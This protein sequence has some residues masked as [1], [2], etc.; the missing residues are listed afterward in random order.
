MPTKPTNTVSAGKLRHKITVQQ[1]TQTS[2]GD[3]GQPVYG[4][5]TLA[6]P[7]ASLDSLG[8]IG[9][10]AEIARQLVATATHE[11]TLRYLAGLDERCRVQWNGRTFN[12]GYIWNHEE[13][14]IW[15]TLLCTEQKTGAV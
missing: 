15:L 2:T 6:T 10:K 11:I 9:K 1:K 14:N 8:A 5:T 3:R 7:Y 4:W 12:I 13:R